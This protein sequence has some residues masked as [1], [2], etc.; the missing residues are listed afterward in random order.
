MVGDPLYQIV[1]VHVAG[2]KY[3]RF[4]YGTYFEHLSYQNLKKIF[5]SNE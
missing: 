5:C 4:N 3:Q 1:G 2:D